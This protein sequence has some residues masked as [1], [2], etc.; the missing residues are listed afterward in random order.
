MGICS[1]SEQNSSTVFHDFDC[2]AVCLII[3]VFTYQIVLSNWLPTISVRMD[4][5]L[6]HTI[7]VPGMPLMQVPVEER[8]ERFLLSVNTSNSALGAATAF[9]TSDLSCRLREQELAWITYKAG[10]M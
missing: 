2:F 1:Q 8:A 6:G 9:S 7:E 4:V 10:D 5:D 3:P